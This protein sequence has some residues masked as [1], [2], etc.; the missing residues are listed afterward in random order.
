MLTTSTRR[1]T[2]RSRRSRTALSD[3]LSSE[4]DNNKETQ[5]AT[6]MIKSGTNQLLM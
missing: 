6:T 2:R 5:S 1:K 3:D 4:A